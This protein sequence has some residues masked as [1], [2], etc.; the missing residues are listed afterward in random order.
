[1]ATACNTD[2][3]RLSRIAEMVAGR[4]IGDDSRLIAGICSI[5]EVEPDCLT[6]YTGR[7]ARALSRQLESSGAQ[8]VLIREGLELTDQA[9]SA[10][11][12]VVA[13]PIAAMA[14]LIP[15][16]PRISTTRLRHSPTCR[17]ASLGPNWQK[18]AGWRI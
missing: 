15:P 14:K 16:L 18:R 17:S 3:I 8:S 4:V 7:S 10:S 5:D 13:D 2:P 9:A 6:L 12:V 1:M 11:Y